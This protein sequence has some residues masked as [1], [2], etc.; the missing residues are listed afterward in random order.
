MKNCTSCKRDL[1]FSYFHHNPNTKDE[2]GSQCKTCDKAGR[3]LKGREK[4]RLLV[5]ELGGC[6]LEC[7]YS[8]SLNALHFHHLSDD[9]EFDV[10]QHRLSYKKLLQEARKCVLLCANCHAEKHE[11]DVS[12]LFYGAKIRYIN[13]PVPHGTVAGYKRCRPS[14]DACRAAWNAYMLPR[15][16]GRT[17][18]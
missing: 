9:K 1:P 8:K 15:K 18:L 13:N 11:I 5:K 12:S 17:R 4:K 10:S 6:C 16:S 3:I 2:H 7:G 14:C